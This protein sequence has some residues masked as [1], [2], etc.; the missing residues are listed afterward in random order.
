MSLLKQIGFVRSFYLLVFA[1][2][3]LLQFNYPFIDLPVSDSVKANLKS[4]TTAIIRWEGLTGIA[5][6]LLVVFFMTVVFFIRSIIVI[7]MRF[8][9]AFKAQV[10]RVREARRAGIEEASQK[11]SKRSVIIE[12]AIVLSVCVTWILNDAVFNRPLNTSV[13]E[14]ASTRVLRNASLMA[15]IV[16]IEIPFLL[17]FVV[18][19]A[20]I[21][22]Y[23]ARRE[24]IRLEGDEELRVGTPADEQMKQVTTFNDGLEEKLIEFDE[25][26]EKISEK[27]Q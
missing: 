14:G 13:V 11:R 15:V 9:P 7:T 19:A 1:Y 12:W 21:K 10:E 17:L 5:Y 6:I 16:A 2:G 3:L 8:R 22:V 27:M 18:I 24:Q 26:V 4:Q 23:Q 20:T 25:G